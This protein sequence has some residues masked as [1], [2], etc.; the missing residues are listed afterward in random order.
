MFMFR[1]TLA[2]DFALLLF[3]PLFGW[4][5]GLGVDDPVWDASTFSKNRTRVL[6]EGGRNG[7]RNFREEKR[8]NETH[9]ST[10][11]PP[12]T[13]MRGFTTRH[14]VRRVGLPVSA[15]R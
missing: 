2:C 3:R 9:A 15:M 11:D 6:T 4:F 7:E 10:T 5:V 12:P 8:S 13:R 14:P 1:A